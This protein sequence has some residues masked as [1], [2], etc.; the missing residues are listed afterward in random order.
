[1]LRSRRFRSLPTRVRACCGLAMTTPAPARQGV[2]IT[3]AASAESAGCVPAAIDARLRRTGLHGTKRFAGPGRACW[4]SCRA[5]CS[6]MWLA[7]ADVTASVDATA[8]GRVAS[9]SGSRSPKTV[10]SP[11][12]SRRPTSSARRSA[13]SVRRTPPG[14]T[15]VGYGVIVS[16]VY[17]KRCSTPD[18][19]WRSS[20]R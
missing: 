3:V 15:S 9:P 12:T 20:I 10:P 11:P 6:G 1:M 2:R 13:C 19:G 16:C 14:A 4:R 8:A 5:S 17:Q 18:S 7:R